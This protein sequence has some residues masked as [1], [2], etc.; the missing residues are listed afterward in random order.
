MDQGSFVYTMFQ[1]RIHG[2]QSGI[3]KRCHLYVKLQ[4]MKTEHIT[5]L[6]GFKE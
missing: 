1:C 4:A 5:A 6:Y 2:R 3:N